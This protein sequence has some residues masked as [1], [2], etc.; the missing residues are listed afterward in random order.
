MLS[1]FTRRHSWLQR[2]RFNAIESL[3]D[4]P[5]GHAAYATAGVQAWMEAYRRQGY[6]IARLDPLDLA[7]RADEA[8]LNP[9][10]FGLAATDTLPQDASVLGAATVH[11]LEARLR[12]LY[13]DSLSLDCSAVRDEA[14]STW[15]FRKMESLPSAGQVLKSQGPALLERLVQT[16]AWEQHVAAC[17]PQAKRFSLEGCEALLPLL[18]ALITQ[19]SAQGVGEILLGMPHRG[20]VN[21]LVNLMGV[22]ARQVLDYFDRERAQPVHQRDLVY[23]L[24][25]RRQ[26]AT[27]H[28][29]VGLS[30]AFNPSHLQSVH[31]VVVGMTRAEQDRGLGHSPG[32]ALALVLHGDAAVAGQ[33]VMM[34]TLMLSQKPG[35]A[36]GGTVH[37]V[38]NNQVGFTEL[39]P[40]DGHLPR[41]CTDVSRMIDA[42]VL[43]VSAD[44]PEQ[45]LRAAQLALAYRSRFGAD[46]FIDLI[47]YRRPGHSEHDVPALTSPQRQA[48]IDA[49]PSVVER[50]AQRLQTA[51]LGSASDW[52]ERIA[53]A[54]AAALQGFS[55]EASETPEAPSPQEAPE[56]ISRYDALPNNL[57]N[58]LPTW[59][60]LVQSLTRLPEGFAPH[61]M[62]QTLIEDWQAMA[63]AEDARVDWRFAENLAFA[64]LLQAGKHVRV[65]G[66]DAQRGTF[67]HRLA[68]WHPQSGHAQ[69]GHNSSHPQHL[70]LQQLPG[71]TGRFEIYNSPLSEEAVLG[72]EYGY[73]LQAPQSLVIWEAQ[74]G[75][76]V[77]GAQVF[78]DQYIASGE[79]K[80]GCASGLTLLLPHGYEG[81]GPEHSNGFLSRF[82]QLCAEGNLQV[83][84]PSTAAQ[85]FHMLRRQA[86][87]RHRKPL[88]VMSPKA[89]LYEEPGSHSP[90]QQL[91]QGQF[92]TVLDDDTG[93]DRSAVERL[94]LCSGKVHYDLL[95][96][97][98]SEGGRQPRSALLRVEQLYPFP[99]ERLA[100][101]LASYPN[102]REV[103][104]AQEEQL[105]QGAWAFVRDAIAAVLPAGLPLRC[106]APPNRAGGASA[107]LAGHREVQAALMAEALGLSS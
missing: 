53:E 75:D 44:A 64:H 30:L 5:P 36:T 81:V 32:Q 78:V 99:A 17:Y 68:V 90:L 80:W 29:E 54:R 3:L 52:Q 72:F 106:A 28:G 50:F 56:A 91:M 34:E 4:C 87:A 41:Y 73:S 22:P 101:L 103:V 93:L 89:V 39:N 94:V 10:N 55:A 49:A 2:C 38:I 70:P 85:Y 100:E 12:S 57:P 79:A 74:F 35:Y 60:A 61:P 65:S 45:L 107:N 59:Q 62:V 1:S 105:N 42:P 88:V 77:N 27:P 92:E 33:G 6:R 95:R 48:Q 43:R 20:R 25:A 13:A 98:R 46:I 67:F 26:L 96:A 97:R 19:A 71:A 31:P 76:F 11:E 21:V 86:L 63:A 47:G 8:A 24:G 18:D 7:P 84:M 102:L 66:M 23:H 40:M 83:L 9:A 15:L 14:R 104:W 69:S 16:Q 58:D 37:V 51:G 82:L